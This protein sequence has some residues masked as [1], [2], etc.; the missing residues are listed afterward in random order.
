MSG[1]MTARPPFAHLVMVPEAEH[2]SSLQQM[3]NDGEV[4]VPV[5]AGMP[6]VIVELAPGTHSL[7]DLLVA[8]R[9]RERSR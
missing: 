7:A 2:P 9:D 6:D 3:I 4:K 1:I 8:D 5:D